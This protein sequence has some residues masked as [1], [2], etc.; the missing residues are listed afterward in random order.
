MTELTNSL[1]AHWAALCLRRFMELTG[2]DLE[3]ALGDLLANLMHWS[4]QNDFDFDIAL[5]RGRF[6][7]EAELV[8]EGEADSPED[9]AGELYE[10]LAGV[11]TLLSG[12]SDVNCVVDEEILK[13][14]EIGRARVTISK[15]ERASS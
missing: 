2:C 9:I 14:P 10:A 6:H 5:D 15:A 4:K 8:E 13:S 3:D 12:L 7:F 11:L 1:R